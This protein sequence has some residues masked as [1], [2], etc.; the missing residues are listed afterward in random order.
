LS[1]LGFRSVNTG[2]ARISGMEF[3]AAG[4]GSV[5]KVEVTLLMGYTRTTPISTTPGEAYATSFGNPPVPIS[6]SNTS[7]DTTDHILKYRVRSLFR[8]DIGLK[9]NKLS[10]GVSVRYNSHVRNIDKA[11]IDFDNPAFLPSGASGWMKTHTTGDWIV[12]A[13][14]GYQLTKQVKAAFIATNLSN[15]VYSIRPM[16][17]EAPR[18]WQVQLAVDL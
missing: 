10:G 13:R 18:S 4:K 15:E 7:Y 2:G 8:S 17:I 5:G 1:R 11:F 6:Y 3:E 14:L 9:W 12:D 16:A